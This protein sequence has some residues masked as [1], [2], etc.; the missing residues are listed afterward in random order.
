MAE[1]RRWVIDVC[2]FCG[3]K[4]DYASRCEHWQSQVH[5]TIPVVV[6][7]TVTLTPSASTP[8]TGEAK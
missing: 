6:T 7:G 2:R 8:E 3:A 5:W 4:A 1:R